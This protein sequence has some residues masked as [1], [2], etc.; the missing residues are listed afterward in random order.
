MD[1]A[2][3]WRP[4]HL[5]HTGKPWKNPSIESF[6][7]KFRDECLNMHVFRDGRYALELVEAW[8]NEYSHE[9]PRSSLNYMTPAEFA[10]HCRNSGRTGPPRRDSGIPTMGKPQGQDNQQEKHPFKICATLRVLSPYSPSVT[11]LFSFVSG[12]REHLMLSRSYPKT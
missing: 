9:R 2:I 12:W 7:D 6:H 11:K 3:P 8:R 4:N 10:A 5:Q 1:W